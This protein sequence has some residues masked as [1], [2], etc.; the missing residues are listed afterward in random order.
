MI[1]AR[2]LLGALMVLLVA[3]AFQI[4]DSSLKNADR[5][6]LYF[7]DG[8]LFL[9]ASILMTINLFSLDEKGRIAYDSV[10]HRFLEYW[11]DGKVPKEFKLCPMFWWTFF[12]LFMTITLVTALSVV[13]YLFFAILFVL[14]KIVIFE[15][16]A[17]LLNLGYGFAI[18]AILAT[19]WATLSG[20]LKFLKVR[21]AGTA[22]A[23]LLIL[24]GLLALFGSA[25]AKSGLTF[26]QALMNTIKLLA[27]G[28]VVMGSLVAITLLLGHVSSYLFP[29]VRDSFL[30]QLIQ[31]GLGK[32]CPVIEVETEPKTRDD[33][34]RLD[35]FLFI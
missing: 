21:D 27:T 30:G 13:I 5:Q 25:V 11:Y 35:P 29:K 23:M 19:I 15:P 4:Y 33:Y 26:T 22:A 6:A 34:D 1:K 12:A 32:L 8:L 18:L 7:I 10:P 17:T 16:Y 9:S 24:Y 3:G 20:V 14:V 31:A 28:F 2:L